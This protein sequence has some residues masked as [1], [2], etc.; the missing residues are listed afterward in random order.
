MSPGTPEDSYDEEFD[1][2]DSESVG[3]EDGQEAPQTASA[4]GAPTLGFDDSSDASGSGLMGSQRLVDDDFSRMSE[5][6]E[7]GMVPA[8]EAQHSPTYHPTTEAA[9]GETDSSEDGTSTSDQSDRELEEE[10]EFEL[11][12]DDAALE[13]SC[14]ELGPPEIGIKSPEEHEG[15]HLQVEKDDTPTGAGVSIQDAQAVKADT[16]V[17]SDSDFEES[18]RDNAEE[19]SEPNEEVK[20]VETDEAVSGRLQQQESLQQG[21]LRQEESPSEDSAESE[22]E[23]S[24]VRQHVEEVLDPEALAVAELLE[25]NEDRAASAERRSCGCLGDFRQCPDSFWHSSYALFAANLSSETPPPEAGGLGTSAPNDDNFTIDDVD[26]A[27]SASNQ[28]ASIALNGV[29]VSSGLADPSAQLGGALCAQN[30]VSNALCEHLCPQGPLALESES[31]HT[32]DADMKEAVQ[33]GKHAISHLSVES[34]VLVSAES[35]FSPSVRNS[36]QGT[37]RRWLYAKPRGRPKDTPA[38]NRVQPSSQRQRA[39]FDKPPWRIC[40]QSYWNPL[41][42]AFPKGN[43]TQAEVAHVSDSLFILGEVARTCPAEAWARI[44]ARFRPSWQ[45]TSMGAGD[46]REVSS[47]TWGRVYAQFAVPSVSPVVPPGRLACD[48]HGDFRKCTAQVWSTLYNQFLPAGSSCGNADVG[49]HAKEPRHARW[50][51]DAK[52]LLAACRA[53]A[54]VS[55]SDLLS[56]I[57]DELQGISF[58]QG[59]EYDEH[60]DGFFISTGGFLTPED[61]DA[62]STFHFQPSAP[63]R[64]YVAATGALVTPGIAL[65]EQSA[66]AIQRAFRRTRELRSKADCCAELEPERRM[67]EPSQRVTPENL[68]AQESSVTSRRTEELLRMQ[69]EAK[70]IINSIELHV[71]L[72]QMGG[73]NLGR[74]A[75]SPRKL[76]SPQSPA[77]ARRVDLDASQALQLVP[78]SMDGREDLPKSPVR[79]AEA[80]GRNLDAEGATSS[81][82]FTI[83]EDLPAQ[84]IPPEYV[85]GTPQG[86][87]HDKHVEAEQ[88]AEESKEQT[89]VQVLAPP[90]SPFEDVVQEILRLADR[91][92]RNERVAKTEMQVFLR[93]TRHNRFMVWLTNSRNWK[94]YDKDHSGTIERTELKTAVEQFCAEKASR[95]TSR[96]GERDGTLALPRHVSESRQSAPRRSGVSPRPQTLPTRKQRPGQKSQ[97]T[98]RPTHPVQMPEHREEKTESAEPKSVSKPCSAGTG[99]RDEDEGDLKVQESVHVPLQHD[100]PL[101]DQMSASMEMSGEEPESHAL[102]MGVEGGEE[103]LEDPWCGMVYDPNEQMGHFVHAGVGQQYYTG[104]S[105]PSVAPQFPPTVLYDAQVTDEQYQMLLRAGL[106]NP[107]P[108]YPYSQGYYGACGHAVNDRHHM[109]SMQ[110]AGVPDGAVQHNQSEGMQEFVGHGVVDG[111]VAT[112]ALAVSYGVSRRPTFNLGDGVSAAGVSPSACHED[113]RARQSL[114]TDDGGSTPQQSNATTTTSKATGSWIL[115]E[116]SDMPGHAKRRS[117]RSEALAEELD[118]VHE[119]YDACTPQGSALHSARALRHARQHSEKRDSPLPVPLLSVPP[120][121]RRIAPPQQPAPKYGVGQTARRGPLPLHGKHSLNGPEVKGLDG[122]LLFDGAT[123]GKYGFAKR[124]AQETRRWNV[125]EMRR[126]SNRSIAR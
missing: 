52:T 87:A 94:T 13:R 111:S 123:S 124:P 66:V 106:L 86:Q 108:T 109:V 20:R 104:H 118:G 42:S 63:M 15:H 58:P 69:L 99:G 80:E 81:V 41:H 67:P 5:P 121:Q 54:G 79:T 90:T 93:G 120:V 31:S 24:P 107:Q 17:E 114:A 97:Q 64:A 68:P 61:D 78:Q 27:V 112:P 18:L 115:L 11:E 3:D 82:E 4:S 49:A 84:S 36:P 92:T 76:P 62:D 60:D 6:V 71:L 110:A 96:K 43:Q 59:L 72:T 22:F 73:L 8:E 32:E 10:L 30:S 95:N 55:V 65:Q 116:G 126:A 122:L 48:I 12:N 75:Q 44:H 83:S 40:P 2:D 88:H 28:A 38:G 33:G 46:F 117:H 53:G 98:R 119:K 85:N 89:Q 57:Q 74:R 7:E 102:E 39:Q 47:A 125:R 21:S 14:A 45:I 9:L 103:V 37:P 51:V 1:G 77:C 56:D 29:D 35:A 50:E 101:T 25:E 113:E 26:L 105:W 70:E 34:K 16:G 19:V 91:H 100:E 23:D